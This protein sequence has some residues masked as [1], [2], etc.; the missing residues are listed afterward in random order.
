MIDLYVYYKVRDAHAAALA[1]LVC[2][3]QARLIQPGAARLLRR[4]E[5]RDGLQT[6]MEVYPDVPD[7]FAAELEAAAAG[8]GFEGLIE[9]PRR[10][11][12]FMEFPP[13]A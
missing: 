11:E 6:W 10:V 8:A 12:V 3:F 5:S 7:S 13:C 9:G 1:P 2:A 4:P